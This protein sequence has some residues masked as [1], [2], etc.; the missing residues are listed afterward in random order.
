MVS[1]MPVFR[2]LLVLLVVVAFAGVVSGCGGDDTPDA[3]ATAE[4]NAPPEEPDDAIEPVAEGK[5][6]GRTPQGKDL[7]VVVQ[8]KSELKALQDRIGGK[9]VEDLKVDFEKQQLVAVFLSDRRPSL[10]VVLTAVEPGYGSLLVQAR[11]TVPGEGCAYTAVVQQSYAIFETERS[12]DPVQLGVTTV[13]KP[14]EK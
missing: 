4:S 13:E 12:V 11:N 5:I 1:R 8:S 2:Y 6:R 7:A 10:R 3:P 14:C 9:S